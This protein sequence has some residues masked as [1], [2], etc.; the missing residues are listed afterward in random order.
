MT[1]KGSFRR[2]GPR[3]VSAAGLARIASRLEIG[4][5]LA[6]GEGESRRGGRV[7]PS[8]LASALEAIAGALAIESGW[9]AAA[10]WIIAIAD[11]ELRRRPDAGSAQEPQEPAPGADAAHDRWQ[12]GVPHRR[13]GWPRP[14]EDRSGSMSSS[15]DR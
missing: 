6:L 10:T 9:E 8:L 3:I 15:M 11:P 13:R 5:D 1:T 12:A 7:R 14:R 4:E 2:A